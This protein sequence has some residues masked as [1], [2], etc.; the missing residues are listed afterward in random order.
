MTI[1]IDVFSSPGCGKCGHAKEV[2]QE[3][4]IEL[5]EDK[6][7]WRDVNILEDIDYAVD[8][9]VL[10]TP[11]IAINGVLVFKSLPSPS[12]LREELVDHLKRG[13]QY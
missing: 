9:G 5:G 10:S 8:L 11:S 2:L 4:T 12:R 1:N 3:L 6:I 13:N 7:N